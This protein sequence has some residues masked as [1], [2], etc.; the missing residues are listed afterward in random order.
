MAP[1]P[2]STG[3]GDAEVAGG[4][5]LLAAAVAALVWA[6]SAWRGSYRAVWQTS[7]VVALGRL[8]LSVD[9]HHWVNDALMAI[10][11]FVVGLEVKRELVEGDLRDPRAAAPALLFVVVAGRSGARGWG[12]PMATDIAFASAVVALVGPRVP[13]SLKLFLL[14]LAVVDDV[15]AILV[16]AVFYAN[17]IEPYF[18]LAAVAVVVGIVVVRRAGVTR[19][20]LYAGLGLGLWL[21][22]YA[23]GVHATIAGVVLGLL[24]PARPASPAVPSAAARLEHLLRPWTSFGVLPVFALANAGVVV[25]A[26]VFRAPGAPAVLCGVV[27][28]LVL[29]KFVGITAAARA[30]AGSGLGHRPTGTTWPMV[31]GVATVGGIG[32]TVSLFIAQLAFPA[33]PLQDAAKLGVLA[34]S[35]LAAGLGA[36]G[37]RRACP[38][39]PAPT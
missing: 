13:P 20:P 10:F 28:G 14:T 18:L 26:D 5:V 25:R 9:L 4:L 21:A 6:N 19:A 8:S 39:P 27:A 34:A 16:I 7:H 32:F 33:G 37:L 38:S 15:G 29:G 11:F 3:G 17:G 31:A 22:T 1:E 36:A 30:A 24:T 2:A 35:V 12:I 23:S